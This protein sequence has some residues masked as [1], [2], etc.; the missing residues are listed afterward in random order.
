MLMLLMNNLSNADA[1]L[2]KE[3]RFRVSEDVLRGIYGHRR[4]A[5]HP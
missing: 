4:M 5:K 2:R 3:F 1:I